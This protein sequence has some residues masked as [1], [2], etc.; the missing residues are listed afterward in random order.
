MKNV[1][2][3]TDLKVNEI[4]I[5]LNKLPSIASQYE[6][7]QDE[8]EYLD[9]ASYSLNREEFENQFRQVDYLKYQVEQSSMNF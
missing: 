2:E 9:E 3:T 1:F 4:K 7:A 5:R 8:L 6:S